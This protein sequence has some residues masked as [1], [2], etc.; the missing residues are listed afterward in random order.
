MTRSNEA[1]AGART[2]A[3]RRRLDRDLLRLATVHEVP[4]V[5]VAVLVDGSTSWNMQLAL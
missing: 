3:V 5:S 1:V 2:G 4:G